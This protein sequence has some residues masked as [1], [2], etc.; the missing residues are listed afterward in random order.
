MSNKRYYWLKLKDDFFEEKLV[1][2]LRKL[3]DGDAVA[4]VYL[5]LLLKTLKTN[6]RILLDG[7]L[8]NQADELALW[9]DEDRNIVKM[10]IDS[11]ILYNVIDVIDND[12]MYINTLETMIGSECDSAER[13]RNLRRNKQEL[14]QC[15]DDVTKCNAEKEKREDI[16]KRKDIYLLEEILK[17]GKYKNILLT[18]TQLDELISEYNATKL[19]K[20]IDEL[21]EYLELNSKQYKN[22][23]LLIQVSFRDNWFSKKSKQTFEQP[24]YDFNEIEREQE[25]YINNKLKYINRPKSCM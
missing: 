17:F 8:P 12:T 5:K 18:Q 9:L 10:T 16:E 13:V 21:S 14:L 23:Y 24:E 3:P 19:N 25:E 7:L 1:R 22:H 20:R 6:G 4:V 2:L 11:L 15:N